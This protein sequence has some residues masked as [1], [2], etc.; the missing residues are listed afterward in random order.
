VHVQPRD[1]LHE[2]EHTRPLERRRAAGDAAGADFDHKTRRFAG[3]AVL[4]FSMHWTGAILRTF[5]G[6]V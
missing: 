3:H 2:L 4:N 1:L 6:C 5:G